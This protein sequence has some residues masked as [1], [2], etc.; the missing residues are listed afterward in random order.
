MNQRPNQTRT[1]LKL[2]S[3]RSI[4]L[5]DMVGSVYIYIFLLPFLSLYIYVHTHTY[6]LHIEITMYVAIVLISDFPYKLNTTPMVFF[7]QS[8]SV[9]YII[10][11]IR[12][13]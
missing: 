13:F 1:I 7:F 5:V 10:F 8:D 9:L 2:S 12:R 4:L 6:V 3:L 11:S